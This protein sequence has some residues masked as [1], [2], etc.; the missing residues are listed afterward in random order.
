MMSSRHK[1]GR[2]QISLAKTNQLLIGEDTQKTP[3]G[4]STIKIITVVI[5][6]FS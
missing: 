5:Y 3:A 6:V 2:F 1:V 4:V